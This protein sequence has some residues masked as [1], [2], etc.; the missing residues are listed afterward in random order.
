MD[1]EN[2]N[3]VQGAASVKKKS[4]RQLKKEEKKRL[5]KFHVS[6]WEIITHYFKYNE[7]EKKHYK[8]ILGRRVG[9]KVWP[10]FRFLI[11]FGLAF[12]VVYPILYMI[13]CAIRP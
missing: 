6:S 3:A 5:S 9:S 10:I 4:R 12:V 1:N 2:I 8:Y 13:T 11:L 7:A